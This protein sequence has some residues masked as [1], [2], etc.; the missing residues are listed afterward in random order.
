MQIAYTP[1]QEALR[2]ELRAYFAEL[3]TP[4]V[5]DEVAAGETG[6][7]HCLDAVRK[8][9]RDGWLGLGWPQEYGGQGRG[10]VDQFIFIDEAWRSGAPIPFLTINTVGKTIQQFGTDEQKRF[11]LP[12]IL[13]GE[14]HFSIGYTE[15]GAGTDLAS[16]RTTAVRDGDV[17]VINGQKIFTSLASYADYIWLAARTDPDAPKH[18]GIT[19]FAVPTSD[20]GFSCSK[21]STMVNASTFHTFYDDVRVPDTAIIGELNRG[22]DLI[23]NQLNYERVSLGPP[24]MFAQVYEDVLAHARETKTADGRRL[25][26]HEWV[27]LNL[28]RVH[29]K[30]D[31]LKLINWKVAS[32]ASHSDDRANPADAS[33]TKVYG[34][35]L[36]V[37]AYRLLMEVVGP[38]SHLRR[39]SPGAILA[40]RLERALQGSLILTFG[41]GTNEVQ[42]DLIA[43]FGLGLPR[44]PRS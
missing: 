30:L 7:P 17:W 35:E 43:L 18:R 13:A 34:T 21:I 20:P 4:E 24:G 10:D 42:R 23:V 33:A 27:R 15:P 32:S 9:G 11:F 25:I 19:I 26:D 29:A 3:M 41:G 14:L 31:F 16:L 37:E 40:G 36:F 1:E 38:A 2:T 5:L 39:G 28:A 44:V 12:R 8:M 22:W 6:G